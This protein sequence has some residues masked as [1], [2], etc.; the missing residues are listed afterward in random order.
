[1]QVSYEFFDDEDH[2]LE[3]EGYGELMESLRSLPG[4]V[5]YKDDKTFQQ[6][7]MEWTSN[8]RKQTFDE[9]VIP[10]IH[11]MTI[12]IRLFYI[13]VYANILCKDLKVSRKINS[14]F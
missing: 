6:E 7:A 3:I 12:K 2:D 5:A 8:F 9:D 13:S 10:Y 11:G 4:S 1:M 14:K